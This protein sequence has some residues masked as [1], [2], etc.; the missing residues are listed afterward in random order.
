MSRERRQIGT[1]VVVALMLLAQRA[2]AGPAAPSATPGVMSY[3]GY[4]TDKDGTPVNNG[5]TNMTF[6]LY[7]QRSGG[8]KLWDEAHTGANAVPV[9]NGL[10]N[11]LLGSLEPIESTVWASPDLY[12]EVQ[13]G[14][15][16]MTPREQVG[17][18]PYAMAAS[19]ALTATQLD[20]PDGDPAA[21]VYV[22][23]SGTVHVNG[24]YYG[25]GH[26][27]LYANEGDGQNGTAYIQ[28]RDDSGISNID[29]QF[30][31]QNAGNYRDVMTLKR[32][33]NVE[34]TGHLGSM[35]KRLYY[36]AHVENKSQVECTLMTRSDYSV[37]YLAK[38]AMEN[39]DTKDEMAECFIQDYLGTWR[40]CASISKGPDAHVWCEAHCLE[41][42][43]VLAPS[44]PAGGGMEG[45][46]PGRLAD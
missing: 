8:T 37:C 43:P 2:W 45:G 22:D 9:T 36:I 29:L 46:R 11:V 25:K 28:A 33:G 7:D 6:R 26:M 34:W 31:T 12:L 30:R 27:W 5:R 3:Q 23:N 15:E 20:A 1:I 21:A 24:D 39:I 10:F 17:R 41:W 13:V 38:V 18:V 16:T 19:H 44:F 35:T 14:N 32:D 4:L 40:L 42:S